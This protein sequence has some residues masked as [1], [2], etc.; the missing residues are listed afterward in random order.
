MQTVNERGVS[1][2]EEAKRQALELLDGMHEQDAVSVFTA[3]GALRQQVTRSTDHALVRRAIEALEAE[4]GGASLSGAIALARAMQRDLP[5]LAIYVYTDDASVQAENVNLLGVGQAMPN[6]SILDASLQPESGTAFA[7]VT[8]WG[9]DGEA[10]LECLADGALCDVRT[11]RLA[12]GESQGSALCRAGRERSALRCALRR[13]TRWLWTTRAMRQVRPGGR[14]TRC[15]LR[16]G[17]CF[18]SAPWR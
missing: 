16:K 5:E 7:R 14:R 8:A 2:L 18:W 11:V 15:W 17:T 10:E 3:G 13:K 4:N 9:E 12:S 1:R 6:R